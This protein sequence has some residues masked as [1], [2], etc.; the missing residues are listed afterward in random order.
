MAVSLNFLKKLIKEDFNKKDQDL[1][2]KLAFIINPA[3]QQ[4]INVLN[5]GLTLSNLAT[6]IKTISIQV[7]ATGTPTSSLS[8]ISTLSTQCSMIQVGRVLNLTNSAVYPS[9]GVLISFIESG[10]NIQIQNITGL[11]PGYTWQIT[12]VAYI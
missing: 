5:N 9:G 10:D 8:F 2:G 1:I 7:D 12:L 6:Q 4:L 3:I 11:S